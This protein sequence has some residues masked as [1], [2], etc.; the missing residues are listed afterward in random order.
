MVHTLTLDAERR[1][2][3]SAAAEIC[4]YSRAAVD[5]ISTDLERRAVP[6]R[7]LRFMIRS[8]EKGV[9]SSNLGFRLKRHILARNRVF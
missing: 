8:M 4:S 6:P 3:V 5:K 2:G 7:Q 1:A 9:K